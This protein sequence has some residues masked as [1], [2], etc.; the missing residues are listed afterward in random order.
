MSLLSEFYRNKVPTRGENISSVSKAKELEFES[1][2]WSHWRS[3]DAHGNSKQEIR[4]DNFLTSFLQH[5]LPSPSQSPSFE[6][7]PL[8]PKLIEKVSVVIH[9]K[10]SVHREHLAYRIFLLPL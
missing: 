4:Y 5:P 6:N 7:D 9:L 10:F 1:I 8:G 3:G 2:H